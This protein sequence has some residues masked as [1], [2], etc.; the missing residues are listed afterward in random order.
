MLNSKCSCYLTD[1]FASKHSLFFKKNQTYNTLFGTISGLIYIFFIILVIILH[2]KKI[3]NRKTFNIISYSQNDLNSTIH[4][5]KFPI[6]FLLMDINGNNI[7][8]DPKIAKLMINYFEGYDS[9]NINYSPDLC[10][11][12]YDLF[13]VSPLIKEM[14]ECAIFDNINIKGRY[15]DQDE[16]NF[17]S[18]SFISCEGDDCYEEEEI[19]NRL[20][21]SYFFL[22]I[23]E[24][25][26][27][28]YNYK[29]PITQTI[30]MENIQFSYD[31]CKIYDFFLSENNYNSDD[32][33]IF[34]N[35]K[36]N[37][38][39]IIENLQIDFKKTNIKNFGQIR[40]MMNLKKIEYY[41]TY[42]KI[43]DVFA[44]IGVWIDIIYFIIKVVTKF[45]TNKIFEI[46]MVNTIMFSKN[47]IFYS[48]PKKDYPDNSTIGL[49]IKQY[50]SNTEI[51]NKKMFQNLKSSK[52]NIFYS[53]KIGKVNLMNNF[54]KENSIN[55]K[56]YYYLNLNFLLKKNINFVILN[57]CKEKIYESISIEYIYP[58]TVYDKEYFIRELICLINSENNLQFS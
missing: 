57:K 26:I 20:E 13:Q 37:N 45:I 12:Y 52:S 19:K 41:R 16:Y 25:Q 1:I 56:W 8:N 28:H 31:L 2:I 5:T 18:F 44:D 29:N 51:M 43:Q 34:N 21:N 11:Q 55:M 7:L 6:M 58:K 54:K 4:F 40:F 17:I 36:I 33:L 3:F 27:N 53:P 23:P 22:F 30:R 48:T 14:S 32:G 42:L 35:H 9:I 49:K 50:K 24:N 46:D 38:F 39:S 15:G 10:D 47:N